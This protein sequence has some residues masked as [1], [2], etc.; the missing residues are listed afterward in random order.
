MCVGGEWNAYQMAVKG[1]MW[2]P[3]YRE[4]NVN[5]VFTNSFTCLCGRSH[6]IAKCCM[7]SA[8]HRIPLSQT[9]LYDISTDLTEFSASYFLRT[10]ST[11]SIWNAYKTQC[12][13]NLHAETCATHLNHYGFKR[14]DT[15]TRYTNRTHIMKYLFR[16]LRLWGHASFQVRWIYL[17]S[18]LWTMDSVG[19]P[20]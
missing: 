4:R 20:S 18:F 13:S 1:N 11:T 16:A 3:E 17:E 6:E 10:Q 12:K 19:L 5:H 15:C 9:M 8:R 7:F 14:H 2:T